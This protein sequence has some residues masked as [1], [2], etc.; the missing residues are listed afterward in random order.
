MAKAD[1]VLSTPPTNTPIDTS[2]RRFLAVAAVASAVG[3]GTLAAAARAPNDVP[4]AVTAPRA[5]QPACPEL[6]VA[7]HDLAKAHTILI[8]AQATNEEAEAMWS[9]WEVQNPQPAS[10]RGRRKWISRGSAYHASVTAPS[11]QILMTAEGVF[12]A[13]QTAVA[14]VSITGAADIEAMASASV[15]Y[16]KVPLARGNRAPIAIMVADEIFRRGMAVVL[17]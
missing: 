16:D 1:R 9:D 5:T 8:G 15:V 14:S 12:A 10:K 11:W 7:L 6:R 13:A 3:A 2:R 4:Q 17:S